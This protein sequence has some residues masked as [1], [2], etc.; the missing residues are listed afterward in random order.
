MEPANAGASEKGHSNW[1]KSGL[2]SISLST[3][4][5]VIAKCFL[6]NITR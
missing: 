4:K 3:K 6:T 2:I 5:R 1:R